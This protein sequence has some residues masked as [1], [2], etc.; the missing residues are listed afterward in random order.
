M[1]TNQDTQFVKIYPEE[2]V[3]QIQGDHRFFQ[4]SKQCCDRTWDAAE[5]RRK[6]IEAKQEMAQVFQRELIPHC[7]VCGAEGVSVGARLR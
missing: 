3:A 4:C 6:M 2:K 5:A 7:P 1:T